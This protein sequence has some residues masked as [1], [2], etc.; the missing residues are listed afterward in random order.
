MADDPPMTAQAS[1]VYAGDPAVVDSMMLRT[2]SSGTYESKPFDAGDARVSGV[3]YTQTSTGQVTY[4][5]RSG[6]TADPG[7]PGWS[8]WGPPR[9]PSPPA[10]S[11]TG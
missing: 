9:R 6:S 5:T 10:T 4:Q 8:A 3:T 7:S 2:V 11:S 1:D